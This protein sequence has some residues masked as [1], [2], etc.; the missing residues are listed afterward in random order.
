ME[1]QSI[2]VVLARPEESRNVGASCR[3]MANSGL[4]SL[5]VVGNREDYDGEKIRALAV[6]AADVWERAAFFPT[7][8]EACADCVFSVGTT[9]RRGRS[10]KGKL[11][12]PE[13][14]AERVFALPGGKCAVVFGNE[15]TGLTDDELA[16]CTLGVTIP[17]GPGFPS[18]N[19]SHAV[20]VIGYT[21]FRQARHFSP[22]S[23]A[24]PL[25]RL[26][27]TVEVITDSLSQ[28]G[29]FTQV[30]PV[31]MA[32]FWRAILSRSALSEGEA[33]YLERLFAKAAGLAGRA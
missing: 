10:R 20:Q 21:L 18:L 31:E 3:A 27:E 7:V 8:T 6:H 1:L 19:L 33:V 9:R 23:L 15:R 12:L 29:F 16:E 5:R 17:A 14:L 13:E 30:P 4:A 24:I 11:L 22:G 2:I 32:R 28:I 26:D 25:A